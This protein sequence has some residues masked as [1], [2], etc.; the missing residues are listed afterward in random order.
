MSSRR[1][2]LVPRRCLLCPPHRRPRLPRPLRLLTLLLL[3]TTTIATRRR[4]RP[5]AAAEAAR[6]V[7]PPLSQNQHRQR[8]TQ[9]QRTQQQK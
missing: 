7:R 3:K 6:R 8:K 2:A 1:S 4:R 9:L 5:A